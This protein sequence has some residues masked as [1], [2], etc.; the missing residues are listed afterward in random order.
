VNFPDSVARAVLKA[1]LEKDPTE[2]WTIG[3]ND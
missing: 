2:R 1:T 3:S